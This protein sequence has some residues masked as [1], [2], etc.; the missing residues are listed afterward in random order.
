[1]TENLPPGATGEAEKRLAWDEHQGNGS[2]VAH[3]AYELS[4][5][6]AQ[7]GIQKSQDQNWAEAEE[8]ALQQFETE[9][10][11]SHRDLP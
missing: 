3:I 9:L 5:D 1:M 7:G 8:I 11:T 2:R 6:C 10:Q 4:K